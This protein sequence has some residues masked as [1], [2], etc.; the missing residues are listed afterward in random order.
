M[1]KTTLPEMYWPMMQ[2]PTTRV[3]H[4]LVCGSYDNLEQH[5]PVKRS[6]GNLYRNG[7]K[8]DKPTI[9]LC[10]LGNASGCHGRAH[11]GTLHFRWAE[12]NP[13]I[14]K[15][16]V[17]YGKGGHWEYLLTDEPVKYQEA[18]GMEGWER[19]I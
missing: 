9:T 11:A 1:D 17:V 14:D 13:T 4:C 8:L 16:N 10:G 2:A 19:C 15:R 5:H 6:A 18:L 3:N 12:T 7:R